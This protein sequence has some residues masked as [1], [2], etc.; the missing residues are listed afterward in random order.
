MTLCLTPLERAALKRI[1]EKYPD[2]RQ[3]LEAQLATATVVR[4]ENSG[5]GFF[6]HLTVDRSTQ[7]LTTLETVFGKVAASIEGFKQPMIL[8][9][10]TKQ[11]YAVML[12]GATIDDSTVG[13]ELACLQFTI[14]SAD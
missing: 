1:S 7:P 5:A 11:G 3:A 10:F 4:R 2:A 8:L 12:E 6:T 14:Q 9:L 13:L